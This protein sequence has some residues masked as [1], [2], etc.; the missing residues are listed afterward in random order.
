METSGEIVFMT[1]AD[2]IFTFVN[3]EF[4]RVY[5]YAAADVVGTCTPRILKS[6]RAL[7]EQYRQFWTSIAQGHV[8][9]GIWTNRARDGSIIDVEGSANPIVDSGRIVG[10]LAVQRDVTERNRQEAALRESE[11]RYRAV[12]GAARDAIFVVDRERR[13]EYMNE[14]GASRF[15]LSPDAVKG[16]PVAAFFAP[17][18]LPDKLAAI[19]DVFSTGRAV[20]R[21]EYSHFPVGAR[22]QSTVLAPILAGDNTVRAVLGVVRD[23]TEQHRLAS[24]LSAEHDLLQ[25]IITNSPIGIALLRG[26]ELIIELVNPAY[27]A[28]DPSRAMVGRRFAD[29]WH[30]IAAARVPLIEKAL[31]TGEIVEYANVV[32]PLAAGGSGST[33]HRTFA[34]TYVPMRLPEHDEAGVAVMLIETTKRNQLEAQFHQAQKMEAVGRLAGGI[35][36]DFNNLLTAILGYADLLAGDLSPTDARRTDVDEIRRAAESAASLTRQLLAFSR[37]QVI[38]PT[39][40][41]LN[42]VVRE[43]E[44]I[45]QRTIGED[46]QIVLDLPWTLDPVLADRGQIEQILLNLAVNARD[47]MPSGGR[48][49]IH[50]ANERLVGDIGNG[51]T[52]VPGDYVHLGVSDT[53]VGMTPEVQAQL[54]EPFFTT[55]PAGKGTGLGLSTVYGIVKQSGGYIGVT[56]APGDGARFDV[57]LPRTDRTAAVNPA[58]PLAVYSQGLK[59]VLVV[60][61]DDALRTLAT[62]ILRQLGYVVLDAANGEQALRVSDAYPRAIDLL[63][64]DIVMPGMSGVSLAQRMVASRP[65]LRVLYMSGYAATALS[66]PHAVP[67]GV[68][69]VQKPFTRDTLATKVRQAL[70]GSA[71]AK[72]V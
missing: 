62:K 51:L 6:G 68:G 1:D 30:E 4:E 43:M 46:V 61:D 21:E 37:K 55:K 58:E 36:H 2:G 26:P 28:V 14:A 41:D 7:P 42:A 33:N 20:R 50:T 3:P 59:T 57:Y 63:V 38:Q 60:E 11:L 39:V 35:A 47:A 71:S 9:K 53:G 17:D 66:Q 24:R 70:D 18:E 48:L 31:H 54:F 32:A 8:V 49:T 25:A 56:S 45:V 15:Q 44:R 22:W 12:A 64:S 23:M 10:Y 5:G 67:P 65:A 29:V 13:F 27:Q 52:V 72:R 40:L 69:F 16:R 34:I 19:D